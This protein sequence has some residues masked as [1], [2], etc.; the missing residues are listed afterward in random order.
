[1][2]GRKTS[3]TQLVKPTKPL[4]QGEQPLL[5]HLSQWLA[6]LSGPRSR[7]EYSRK[8]VD[9][10][11][12]DMA[13]VPESRTPRPRSRP[14]SELVVP[15]TQFRPKPVHSIR[16]GTRCVQHPPHRLGQPLRCIGAAVRPAHGGV[17]V[18]P[19]EELLLHLAP[20]AWCPPQCRPG[21]PHTACGIPSDNRELMCSIQ[22]HAPNAPARGVNSSAPPRYYRMAARSNRAQAPHRAIHV[23]E[24]RERFNTRR[25]HPV[26]ARSRWRHPDHH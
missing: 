25:Y 6:R 1:M 21:S 11:C 5:L 10:S 22:A 16:Q 12:D 24:C 23:L 14:A 3:A 4:Q 15:L 9:S 19:A 26:E 13:A 18:A 2:A 20:P 8:S 7:L 17:D